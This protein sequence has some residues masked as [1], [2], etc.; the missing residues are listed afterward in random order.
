METN[1][2]DHGAKSRS[3]QGAAPVTYNMIIMSLASSYV[4]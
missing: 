2:V 1:L 3:L 4:L